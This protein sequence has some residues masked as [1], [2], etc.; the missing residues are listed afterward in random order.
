MKS[1]SNG[2]GAVRAET[3]TAIAATVTAVAALSIAVW[4]NVQTRSYNRVSVQPHLVIEFAKHQGPTGDS[5][6]LVLRNEGIGPAQIEGIT[7]QLVDREGTARSY[8]SW[9]EARSAIRAENLLALCESFDSSCDIYRPSIVVPSAL[10]SDQVWLSGMQT[11]ADS[12][13]FPRGL[14]GLFFQAFLNL[15]CTSNSIGRSFEGYK[16]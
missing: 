4:D 9:N 15:C 14:Y 12:K 5:G 11:N 2:S 3:V 16:E 7:I 10:F 1:W 8:G 6:T 13:H